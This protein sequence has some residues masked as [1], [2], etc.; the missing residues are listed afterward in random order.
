MRTWPCS[1]WLDFLLP[2]LPV[3][4]YPWFIAIIC[5]LYF[6]KGPAL[7]TFANADFSVKDYFHFEETHHD[8]TSPLAD[9]G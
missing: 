2:I 7:L 6:R 5:L 3:G 1:C 9:S 4:I 8:T